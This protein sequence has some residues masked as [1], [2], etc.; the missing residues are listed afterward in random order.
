[1]NVLALTPQIRR[2]LDTAVH[3][4]VNSQY[5]SL[6]PAILEEDPSRAARVVLAVLANLS[7]YLDRELDNAEALPRDRRIMLNNDLWYVADLMEEIVE[8][9][10]DA[11]PAH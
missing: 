8:E 7:V 4:P 10:R 1:V 2:Y 6:W 11:N 3:M 9:L 5:E